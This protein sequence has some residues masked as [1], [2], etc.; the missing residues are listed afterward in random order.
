M[1]R[2]TYLLMR[3]VWGLL[4]RLPLRV[5]MQS[6]RIAGTVGWFLSPSYRKLVFR[7]LSIAFADSLSPSEKHRIGRE[8]FASLA[9]N[10]AAGA[11]LSRVPARDLENLV[12]VEGLEHL[13]AA[14][15][16]GRGIIGLLA[17]LGNW[18]LLARL[19]P[20][21]FQMPCGSVY[22][23]LHNSYVD[24]WVRKARAAEGLELFARREGLHGAMNLLRRG[25]IIGVLSDQHAGD[26]GVWCSLFGRLASTS[27]L[28]AT[29]ALRTGAPI[30]GI[31]LYT[32]PGGRWKMVIRPAIETANKDV[33]ALTA[34]V[35]EELEAMIRKAPA[36]WLWSHNRW[37]TPRPHFLALGKKRGVASSHSQP[38][39]LL[40]RSVNWLGD[41]VMTVPAVRAMR[42]SRPDL[43]ITVAC[44]PKLVEL[45]EAV[46]EVDRVIPLPSSAGF[47][48]Q[49]RTAA[50]LLEPYAFDAAV[51]FPNSLRA[52]L[53]VWL[54]GIPRRVGYRG[55]FRAALFN[56]RLPAPPKPGS[57]AKPRHQ[58]HHYLNLASF[59]G[60]P[61]IPE[62]DWT[63]AA[64]ESIARTHHAARAPRIAVCPGA[65]F[66]GAKRWLPERFAEAMRLVS[67]KRNVEWVLVGVPKD[68]PVGALIEAGTEGLNVENLIGKT[69]LRGLIDL[70]KQCDA[71]LTNDTGTMHLAAMLGVP[72]VAV[73]GSTEPLLTG[74]I[75]ARSRV[76]Q[77]RVPCGPCFQRECHLD[78]SCMRGVE[79]G[80]AAA[81]L[82]SCIEPA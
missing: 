52:G 7:N 27:P 18:E 29:M 3:L 58:V 6:A 63:P 49:V 22:Q 14:R 11:C 57:S 28:V 69:G 20:G 48:S 78:F 21:V 34:R 75:G 43:E 35:N 31:A 32:Q 70:L 9:A 74:P 47:F 59:M 40:V 67:E 76:L 24:A 15:E 81:A 44:Q 51:V 54:A 37:K 65:E 60:A 66:G 1:E 61:D 30:L 79:A 55:H 42:A 38:F 16:E 33:N 26:S 82:I 41:A 80:Q 45:W 68:T 73:F 53:E 72:L 17:H 71:L 62:A 25:G 4:S 50:A 13:V 23:S 2:L 10:I 39:R 36:D 12:S 56:Q 77:H 64:R 8:H 19:S 5:V 46:P